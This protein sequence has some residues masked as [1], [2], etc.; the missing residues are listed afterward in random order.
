MAK[1]QIGSPAAPRDLVD[2]EKEL[3]DLMAKMTTRDIN[4][5]MAVLG[6]RRVGK[7]SILMKLHDNLSKEKRIIPI[8]FDVQ[9]NMAEPRIFFERLQ[10]SIFDA[11]RTKLTRGKRAKSSA[12]KIVGDLFTKI[13]GA[14]GDKK[15]SNISVSI[16]PEGVIVPKVHLA[17]KKPDYAGLFYSVFG[18]L[19]VLAEKNNLKF[20]VILD[21]F[22]DLVKFRGYTGLKDIPS[23]FR[24]VIQ[25]RG[26]HVSYIISGSRVHMSTGMLDGGRSPLFAHFEKL[27]VY[28]MD[29]KYSVELFTKYLSA[30]GITIDEKTAREA[31][32]IVGGIPFYL[33]ALAEAYNQKE[34][35]QDT[36]TRILT[37]TV[38]SLKNYVDYVL[39]E[40]L[41]NVTGGPVLL[42]ILRALAVSNGLTVTEI[43]KKTKIKYT[44]LPYHMSNLK[45]SDLVI[46]EERRYKVRDKI[47]KDYLV[48]EVNSLA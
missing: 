23:L 4:Y 43:S 29:E 46:Q 44:S 8:Y 12:I 41:G 5:N 40:D 25:E 3:K 37:E 36:Y 30:K 27:T 38:G 20:V 16:T 24:A 1:F 42:T 34:D 26:E 2:R 45:N 7:S 19:Q 15:I 18:T 48:F 31:Y 14:I 21:E 35:L 22:Q 28:G 9:K 13:T 6:Y 47:V 33:M 39:S 32:R 11:Y 17:D 10:K